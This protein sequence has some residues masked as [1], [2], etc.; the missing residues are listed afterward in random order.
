MSVDYSVLIVDSDEKDQSELS[1]VLTKTFNIAEIITT[2]DQQIAQM[3]LNN[4]DSINC[5]IV[6]TDMDNGNGFELI[7]KIKQEEKF[8]NTSVL[9]LSETNS[10]ETL[11]QAAAC[12][13][14]EL[15][16][17]PISRRS[18]SLKLKRI[19]NGREF[20]TIERVSLMGAFDINANFGSINDYKGKLIDI[21]IGGCSIQ[22]PK[23]TLGETVYDIADLSVEF[24][25]KKLHFPAELIRIEKDPETEDS[26]DKKTL[27]AFQLI[28]LTEE[29]QAQLNHFIQSLANNGN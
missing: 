6:N 14:T 7:N 16:K 10:R 25:N 2:H 22:L 29:Q 17:K 18:L 20:R 8:K 1:D 28:N 13:V 23:L 27:C 5:V 19:F 24:E 26:T 11:L 15:L 4:R 21:S 3:E 12:G 9:M